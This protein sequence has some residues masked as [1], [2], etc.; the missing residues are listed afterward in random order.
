[1]RQAAETLLANTVIE[2]F[3]VRVE[4]PPSTDEEDPAEPAEQ[5]EFATQGRLMGPK[6][7]VVTF[8]GSLDDQDALRAIRLC[9]G[10]PVP[11]WHGNDT[12]D[13]VQAVI[14]PAGSPMGTTCAAAPSRDSPRDDRGDRSRRLR[15]AGARH[16]QRLS[17]PVR[18]P[19]AA[20][21]ADPQRCAGLCLQGS[22]SSS[23]SVDTTWTSDFTQ[24]QVI[25]LVLKSGAATW[26]MRR[27]CVA[28]RARA[29]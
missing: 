11:L 5:A 9:G 14:L 29:R 24:G 15:D 12:L 3:N 25:T 18:G 28:W 23:E 22:R 13:D 8:P 7:G 27:P 10:E 4:E 1:M 6:I 26:P 17:D 20:R 2:T 16:L 21:R 19:P